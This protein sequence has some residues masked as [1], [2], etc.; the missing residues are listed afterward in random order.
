MEADFKVEHG[1]Q[2]HE[3]QNIS[4]FN[5]QNSIWL[6]LISVLLEGKILSLPM[7]LFIT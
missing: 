4:K 1:S 5:L 6:A 7:F 2:N 3:S